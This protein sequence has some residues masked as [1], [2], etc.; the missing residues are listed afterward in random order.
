MNTHIYTNSTEKI[1]SN[2]VNCKLLLARKEQL[3]LSNFN[4]FPK[5]KRT[6]SLNMRTY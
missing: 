4:L 5:S 1:A 6:V 2:W 3:S